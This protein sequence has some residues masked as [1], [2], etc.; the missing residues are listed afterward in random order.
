MLPLHSHTLYFSSVGLSW[1]EFLLPVMGGPVIRQC[2]AEGSSLLHSFSG[3]KRHM[4]N[5]CQRE[6]QE[7]AGA[8]RDA[9]VHGN[10]LSPVARTEG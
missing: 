1:E 7:G 8:A 5:H 4:I 9:A 6:S 3:T 2:G 10:T